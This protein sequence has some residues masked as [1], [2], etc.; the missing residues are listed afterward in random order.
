VRPTRII[1]RIRHPKSAGEKSGHGEIS[2]VILGVH[3]CGISDL[4]QV[5]LAGDEIRRRSRLVQRRQQYR[6]QQGDNSD[7]H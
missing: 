6:D 2:L 4:P 3:D 7:Y 1:D 5:G